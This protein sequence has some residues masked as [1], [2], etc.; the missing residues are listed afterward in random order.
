MTLANDVPSNVTA[1]NAS[2]AP[3]VAAENATRETTRDG[4][5]AYLAA[6]HTSAERLFLSNLLVLSCV[7]TGLVTAC[8]RPVGYLTL[9]RRAVPLAE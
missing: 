2:L 4:T 9:A 7:F 3:G 1:L 8:L 5:T 6:L